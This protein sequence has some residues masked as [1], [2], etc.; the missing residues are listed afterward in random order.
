MRDPDGIVRHAE[1]RIGDAMIEFAESWPG[2][3]RYAG[4]IAISTLKTLMMFT[5]GL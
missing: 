3:E 2:M 1:A 4:R 5:R